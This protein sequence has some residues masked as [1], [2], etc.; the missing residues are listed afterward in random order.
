VSVS[1]VIL[2]AGLGSRYGGLKQL[3]SFGPNGE[4]LMEFSIYDAIR[5]G[6]NKVVFVIRKDMEEQFSKRFI[7]RLPPSITTEV[8]F[9]ELDNLPDGF[10]LPPEREKPWGTAHAV[11]QAKDAIMEPFAVMNGDDYYGSDAVTGMYEFLKFIESTKYNMQAVTGYPL[12]NTLSEHG[13]VSRA[14][15]KTDSAEN[16]ESLNEIKA[17]SLNSEGQIS[18]EENGS[19]GI[20]D[21]KERV[22]LNLMGFTPAIFQ[23]LE[24]CFTEFLNSHE[25]PQQD[26][27]GLPESLNI[28]LGQHKQII[29]MLK[30][31]SQW[32]GVTY[33]QDKTIVKEKIEA[34][35]QSGQ[36]PRKGLW[37]EQK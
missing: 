4:T 32:F 25:N 35:I 28:I 21:E 10:S 18:Y 14:V 26:E 5:A 29:R 34:L 27:F 30:T 1:L 15:L 20:L 3:D 37:D 23:S 22:S 24:A 33:P 6:F 31:A 7:N 8:V 17:I 9:Q 16:V 12:K 13:S 11:L 36:Y 2:A 19:G